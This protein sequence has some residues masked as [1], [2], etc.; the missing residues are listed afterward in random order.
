MRLGERPLGQTDM[1]VSPLALGCWPLAG[2]TRTGVSRD[3]AIQTVAAALEHGI[4]H[5]D[6]A[7]CYGEHGESEHA[8]A[9]AMHGRRDQIVLASKCGIHWGP[10]RKQV[11]D[12]SPDR[13]QREVEESLSR[14]Q[15]DYLDMLYL[16]TPDPNIPIEASASALRG[17]LDSGTV[18]AIGLSNGSVEACQRFAAVCPLAGCQRHFNMLQQEIRPALLPWCRSNG[19]SLFVYWPLMKGLLAGG[20]ARDRVFPTTDSRHK[21]PMFQGEEYQRNLDFVDAIQQVADRLNVSLV[22]LVLAWT[23]AQ[24][25]ITSV[26]VGATSAEQIEANASALHCHLDEAAHAEIVEAIAR[27]GPVR[28]GRTV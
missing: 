6:T 27:R 3:A 28:G 12:G 25:G 5:L 9:A 23:M 1:T 18:R 10:D 20:M 16:H 24:S 26:L 2:M 17:L 8:V 11:I 22:A 7:Y 4:T 19:V 14:L 21:Y 13:I 15:T